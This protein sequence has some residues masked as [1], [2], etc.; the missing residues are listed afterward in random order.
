MN[1]PKQSETKWH[2]LPCAPTDLNALI[3]LMPHGWVVAEYRDGAFEVAQVWGLPPEMDALH[4]FYPD[5]GPGLPHNARIEGCFEAWPDERTCLAEWDPSSECF[6]L[7][8]I[9][10]LLVYSDPE[11]TPEPATFFMCT[12][13][14]ADLGTTDPAPHDHCPLCHKDGTLLLVRQ[15]GVRIP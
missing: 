8:T 6:R 3:E 4:E 2:N 14:E 13:C 12:A 7:L 5:P 10:D 15:D 9:D 11:G 1:H